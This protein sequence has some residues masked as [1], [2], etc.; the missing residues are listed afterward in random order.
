MLGRAGWELLRGGLAVGVSA[1]LGLV[2]GGLAGCS[3]CSAPPTASGVADQGLAAAVT[4]SQPSS[5]GP[6][7]AV[8]ASRSYAAVGSPV[9]GGAGSVGQLAAP[10]ATPAA[11]ARPAAPA[12]D[13]RDRVVY[14]IEQLIGR[15]LRRLG[16][17]INAA[18]LSAGWQRGRDATAE[19]SRRAHAQARAW[20]FYLSAFLARG[21]AERFAR[22]DLAAGPLPEPTAGVR[23]GPPRTAWRPLQ[24]AE[25]GGVH[26][27]GGPLDGQGRLLGAEELTQRVLHIDA[28]LGALERT[29]EE[30]NAQL[31]LNERWIRGHAQ[32]APE[33]REA[34][35]SL[36]QSAE[37]AIGAAE[38]M[39][40]QQAGRLE[41]L[42]RESRLRD[43]GT[44]TPRR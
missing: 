20:G 16:D 31:D 15:N 35:Q 12:A 41:A 18:Y 9:D 19:E 28:E 6:A 14:Q 27:P 33:A 7:V 10:D 3:A 43:R 39:L 44:T 11:L 24:V 22:R 21:R 13:F 17:A 29:V 1:L 32:R 2:A 23:V 38:A 5:R 37:Q 42:R 26:A 8:D 25:A 30:L 34:A 36:V 4:V 40:R